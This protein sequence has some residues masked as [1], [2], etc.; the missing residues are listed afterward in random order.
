MQEHKESLPPPKGCPQVE[1]TLAS[2]LKSGTVKVGELQGVVGELIV[3]LTL[4][5]Q[6][7]VTRVLETWKNTNLGDGKKEGKAAHIPDWLVL[8]QEGNIQSIVEVKAW[9]SDVCVIDQRRREFI[10]AWPPE[11]VDERNK[12]EW[13]DRINFYFK[14]GRQQII[15]QIQN[16]LKRLEELRR[17]GIIKAQDNVRVILYVPE[18]QDFGEWPQLIVTPKD[19]QGTQ[20]TAG[21]EVRYLPPL[22]EIKQ[23]VQKAIEEAKTPL[24]PEGEKPKS[25]TQAEVV[26]SRLKKMIELWSFWK[27]QFR[28]SNLQQA[29]EY[30]VKL[31]LG[32]KDIKNKDSGRNPLQP[33]DLP[34][35]LRCLNSTAP[36]LVAH[37]L[38]EA[39]KI[40]KK[41]GEL[42]GLSNEEK[43][44][45]N[46][47]LE[48][49][50]I[51][52]IE[53]KEIKGSPLDLFFQTLIILR[54][55]LE[56]KGWLLPKLE[57]TLSLTKT[58]PFS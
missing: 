21:L 19:E 30:I 28:W 32:E 51:E 31:L 2:L 54:K 52:G 3:N 16:H 42:I 18:G 45:R 36:T 40:P 14:D 1:K 9:V 47:F 7:R 57:E 10:K 39:S 58:H 41:E 5:D 6:E 13:E 26:K 23:I 48:S 25:Q 53:E 43:R 56:K 44:Q 12:K 35:L 46:K 33:S 50:G 29:N 22:E 55:E 15:L 8:D 4:G 24:T 11:F 20:I 27:E 17:G 34:R 37:F 49:L 38:F